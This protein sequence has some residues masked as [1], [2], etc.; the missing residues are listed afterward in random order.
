MD[1][2]SHL[3]LAD[4]LM[5][6]CQ[7]G[8]RDYIGFSLIPMLD[9][10]PPWYHR[11]YYHSFFKMP[12]II[13]IGFR[14]FGDES[15]KGVQVEPYSL[16][17]LQEDGEKIMLLVQKTLGK[18]PSVRWEPKVA[19]VAA[20]SHLYLDGFNNPVQAFLPETVY[21]SGEWNFWADNNLYYKRNTLYGNPSCLSKFHVQFSQLLQSQT[22]IK[23]SPDALI[24]SIIR[25]VAS[26][27]QP[28]LES[29]ENLVKVAISQLEAELNI[30][31]EE[32]G[33]LADQL[34]KN[35]EQ[36]LKLA[37]DESIS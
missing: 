8:N 16:Q 15:A 31:L 5:E 17:R 7:G 29:T 12:E 1:D 19:L 30:K 4:F 18:K 9:N 28:K 2:L 23:F 33:E 3:V 14:L 36:D 34:W 10:K 26:T 27:I 11:L 6:V 24:V 32:G 21:C 20:T 13:K 35:V 22:S 37:L 25:R